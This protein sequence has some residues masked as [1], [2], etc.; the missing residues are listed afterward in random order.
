MK[1]AF[2]TSSLIANKGTARPSAAITKPFELISDNRSTA[3]MRRPELTKEAPS[4]V[5]SRVVE[6]VEPK[7]SLVKENHQPIQLEKL[8]QDRL[9][10][11]KMSVR[12]TPDRH[13]KLKI[14][15]AYTRKSAQALITEA[16]DKFMADY[17]V[18][19]LNGQCACL[20]EKKSFQ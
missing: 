3:S 18:N 6:K 15:S 4:P 11:V 19:T 12:M 7:P 8:K 10:R 14:L 17:A 16:L 9:G 1:A 20:N 13:L 2:L 5:L